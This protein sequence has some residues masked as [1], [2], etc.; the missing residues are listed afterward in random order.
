MICIIFTFIGILMFNGA[1]EIINKYDNVK[2]NKKRIIDIII[3]FSTTVLYHKYGFT[4]Q[5]IYFFI[6]SIYLYV[7]AYIDHMTFNVYSFF[8]YAIM[9]ISAIY[10]IYSRQDLNIVYILINAIICITIS[11]VLGKLKM[12]GKGDVEVFIAITL[13][14]AIKFSSPLEILLIIMIISNIS[15]VIINNKKVNFKK[16]TLKSKIAYVPYIAFSTMMLLII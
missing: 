1:L 16:L 5:F 13:P 6:I 8:N 12:Y 2:L 10:I 4:V 7:S 9:C 15:I 14:I 3:L 11:I